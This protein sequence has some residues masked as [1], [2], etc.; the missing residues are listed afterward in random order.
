[1]K[2]YWLDLV[3]S[4]F[5]CFVLGLTIKAIITPLPH[6]EE[7]PLAGQKTFSKMEITDNGNTITRRVYIYANGS[8][9]EVF[10]RTDKK[11]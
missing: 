3:L 6:G 10:E 2:E 9:W 1:M 8:W 11:P 7:I 5:V 4:C